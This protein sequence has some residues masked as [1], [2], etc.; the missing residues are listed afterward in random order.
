[1]ETMLCISNCSVENQI[2]F[3]TY[4]LLGSALTWWNSHVMTVGPYG[5]YAM[6]LV[7]MKKKMTDKKDCLKFK[8][9]NCCTQGGNAN[10][11]A[12]V[13]AVGRAGTNLDSNV[14]TE[15]IVCIPWGNEILI[16][17]G[18][19]SDRGNETLL[20]IILC[21]KT[22]R[23]IQKGCHVFLAH[24]TTK[25]T[26]DKLEKKRL[27]DVP[28]VRNFPEVFP[29]DLSGLPLTRQVEFQIDLIPGVAPVA[30]VPYR[31]APSEM[32]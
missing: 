29:E 26:K 12:K 20:N 5:A 23:Y 32:K 19:G 8:N 21:A 11:P 17:H 6:T 10:A 7:D 1:M 13:Y 28:V 27:E 30:R 24:I 3:T 2:K 18:D 22:Q 16:V 25:E 15:K 9:K 14:V 31:L 4:T